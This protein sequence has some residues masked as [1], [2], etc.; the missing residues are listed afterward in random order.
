MRFMHEELEA[1]P[2][3]CGLAVLEALAHRTA[4]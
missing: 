2:T 1:N 4:A 3:D